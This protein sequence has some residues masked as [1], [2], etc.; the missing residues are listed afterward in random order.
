[1]RMPLALVPAVAAGLAVV[2]LAGAALAH[3]RRRRRSTSRSPS[4]RPGRGLEG[5]GRFRRHRAL[6]PRRG[7]GRGQRRQC[8][9]HDPR[10]TLK[11]GGT[12]VEG[13][14]EWLADGRTYSYR[15]SDRT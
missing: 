3:G 6:A 8:R 10:V 11:A 14:D 12:L 5:G 1:M 15:M 13:L 7:Q 9:G 2:G 4:R